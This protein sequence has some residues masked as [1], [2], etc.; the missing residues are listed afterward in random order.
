MLPTG[1]P[2]IFHVIHA[3]L[4]MGRPNLLAL[5]YRRISQIRVSS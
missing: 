1:V 4:L 3:R 2:T 5:I